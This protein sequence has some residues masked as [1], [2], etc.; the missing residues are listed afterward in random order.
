M[1]K[2]DSS[3][4]HLGLHFFVWTPHFDWT[5]RLNY[6]VVIS[7]LGQNYT[8]VTRDIGNLL[9]IWTFYDFPLLPEREG[10]ILCL[11][12]TQQGP[13]ITKKKDTGNRGAEVERRRRENRGAEVERRR[14][15]NQGA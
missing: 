7:D 15:D 4:P 12:H 14:L 1:P 8:K 13:K 9:E 5:V 11:T 2:A 10:Q 6:T 3:F